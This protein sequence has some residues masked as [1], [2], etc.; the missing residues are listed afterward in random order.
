MKALELR[1][2]FGF[3]HIPC[4][5]TVL[6]HYSGYA[7]ERSKCVTSWC[8]EDYP[9][10]WITIQRTSP[11]LFR[12]A[13]FDC[14]PRPFFFQ[15]F[16][17]SVALIVPRQVGYANG[18][19]SGYQSMTHSRRL[20]WR[21]GSSRSLILLIFP[22][23]EVRG[24]FFQRLLRCRCL[25]HRHHGKHRYPRFQ[26]VLGNVLRHHCLHCS[27]D[28]HVIGWKYPSPLTLYCQATK[29]FTCQVQISL[30]CGVK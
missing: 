11:R 27:H 12:C 28:L 16:A 23:P 2:V 15:R 20:V 4:V 26:F 10:L 30:P 1:K 9:L 19:P 17:Y 5:C 21:N 3:F 8:I 18:S 24:M 6:D 29:I 25:S 14:A 13:V 22:F 7:W